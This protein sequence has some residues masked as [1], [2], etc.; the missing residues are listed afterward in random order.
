LSLALAWL[1]AYLVVIAVWALI[2]IRR[3]GPTLWKGSSLAWLNA[4]FIIGI[5]GVLLTRFMAA[6]PS[7]H[8]S[9]LV[10]LGL[11]LAISAVAFRRTWLLVRADHLQSLATLQRCFVQTRATPVQRDDAYVVQCAGCEMTVSIRPNVLR[12]GGTSLRMPGYSVRFAG[13]G[14]SKK[15]ALIR[16]L[17]SKQFHRSVPTPR[18]K[19]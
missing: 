1:L 5:A 12:I 11:L 3:P 10:A 4:I 8:S 14:D 7:T 6:D 17:F 13:G 16:D 9:A 15:A 2:I 18:I 19:A